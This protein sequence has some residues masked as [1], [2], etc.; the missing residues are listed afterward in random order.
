MKKTTAQV[1]TGEA[2]DVLAPAI[3]GTWSDI[4]GDAMQLEG[5]MTNSVALELCIDAG[6]LNN[7]AA[8]K[9]L[10]DSIKQFGY[11]AVMKFLNKRVKLYP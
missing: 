2:M 7:K 1:L 6:R 8:D 9:I 10:D 4:A 11:D 5:R 3:L